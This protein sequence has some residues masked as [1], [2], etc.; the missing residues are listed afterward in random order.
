M[1]GSH[2]AFGPRTVRFSLLFAST[3]GRESIFPPPLLPLSDSRFFL[4]SFPPPLPP[5]TSTRG[6]GKRSNNRR[7][8]RAENPFRDRSRR[9]NSKSRR[10]SERYA[11]QNYQLIELTGRRPENYCR[12]TTT[13]LCFATLSGGQRM[14]R[15]GERGRPVSVRHSECIKHKETPL[16]PKR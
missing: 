9:T 11:F 1:H 14:G 10:I 8:I 6:R 13:T 5:P 16:S 2:V 12:T 4:S 15:G 3:P 7:I